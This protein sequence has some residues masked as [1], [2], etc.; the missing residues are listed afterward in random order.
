[1]ADRID[2]RISG[3]GGQGVILSGII[4]AEASAIY[5]ETN[6]VQTQ[7]YGPEARGGASKSE[8]IIS[9]KRVNYPKVID[10]DVLV[11]LNQESYDKYIGDL[12]DGGTL[13]VDDSIKVSKEKKVKV[14]RLSL[15][16]KAKEE[17]G[18]KKVANI[19]ALGALAAVTD[20]ISLTALEQVIPNR[21]P[22][23]TEEINLK[24]L[25]LGG[26]IVN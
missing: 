16:A 11:A 14:Y 19:L 15:I 9:Q 2:I 21:V 18:T 7:A 4:L 8:V 25:K 24:A 22:A 5:D 17:L 12:E 23:G 20:L 10:L 13:I 6:A 26:K 1:M 3:A